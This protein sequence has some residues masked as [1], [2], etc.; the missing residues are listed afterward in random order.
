MNTKIQK[1]QKGEITLNDVQDKIFTI[2]NKNV[3]LDSDVA[4]LYDANNPNKFPEGY[5]LKLSKEEKEK[6]IE[7]F[8]NPKIKFSPAL[9]K[10]FLKSEKMRLSQIVITPKSNFRLHF[11]KPLPKKVYIRSTP[12]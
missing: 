12:F 9:P 8:D 11:Q 1:I 3:L 7:S 2:R 5:V 4:W 10:A 6:V